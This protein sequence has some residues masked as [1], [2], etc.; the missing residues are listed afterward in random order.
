VLEIEAL[1]IPDVKLLLPK[2]FGDS[3]GFMSETFH[4]VRFAEAGITLDFLQENHSRSEA[5]GTV[6]GLHFQAAPAAQAKL[7][8]VLKG[9]ILDIVVDIRRA[10]PYYGQHVTVE[11]SAEN[12][13]QLYIPAGFAHG[14]CTLERDTEVLY[15]VD[16]PYRP[17]LE[18][19]IYW[20]DPDLGIE[21]PVPESG[22]ILSEKDQRLALWA[23][24]ESPF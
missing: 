22:A 18:G 5:A 21:W 4:A 10:S 3:R 6:R 20:A 14:F 9:A 2:R 15:K 24:F 8:R 16:A 19:G 23:D 7:V 13:R 1:T 11:L 12:W 17:D